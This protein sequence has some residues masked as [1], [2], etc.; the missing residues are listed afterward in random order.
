MFVEFE[1]WYFIKHGKTML[2]VVYFD[3]CWV[4]C[5]PNTGRNLIFSAFFK[6]KS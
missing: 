2:E 1:I 4:L 5:T 6:Q 3:Q